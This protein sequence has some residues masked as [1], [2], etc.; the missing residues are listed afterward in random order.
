ML[1]APTEELTDSKHLFNDWLFILS[2]D[3][4]S[5]SESTL[6]FIVPNIYDDLL[7]QPRPTN[8]T[9]PIAPLKIHYQKYHIYPGKPQDRKPSLYQ[10]HG[11]NPREWEEYVHQNKAPTF[12]KC[13]NTTTEAAS[14]FSGGIA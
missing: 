4:N 12:L 11:L 7:L 13:M 8:Q 10:G 6:R 1:R 14:S 2:H 5:Q 9:A 3:K